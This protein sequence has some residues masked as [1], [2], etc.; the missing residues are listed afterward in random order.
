M[1]GLRR[2]GERAGCPE[3]RF[4][5]SIGPYR[6]L[7]LDELDRLPRSEWIGLQGRSG[8][9]PTSAGRVRHPGILRGRRGPLRLRRG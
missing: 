4:I 8:M 6:K 1:T 9:G 3:A 5:A 2:N 7:T